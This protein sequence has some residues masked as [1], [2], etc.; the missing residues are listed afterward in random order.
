[1]PFHKWNQ[2]EASRITVADPNDFSFAVMGD[3]KGNHSVFEPLAQDIDHDKEIRFAIDCG[4]L[5]REGRVGL[6][7]RFL[8][9][10]QE[11]LAIPFLTAIGNHDLND[12]GSNKNYQEIFG[13]TY[14]SFQ[15]GQGYFI[16]LDAI[17]EA[18]FDKKER[19]WLENELQKSQASKACFVFMHVPV[20]DPRGGIFHKSLPDKDQQDLLDLFR[21]YKVTHLFASHLHGYFSGIWEGVP[22]TLTGGAGARLQGTDPEHFF[23][24]YVKVHVSQGKADI[25]VRR[26]DTANTVVFF[27]DLMEDYS[28]QWGLLTAAGLLPFALGLSI[29]KRRRSS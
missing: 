7:R 12:D 13:P 6:Y 8:Q 27:F 1:V 24:H 5:V 28:L 15:V 16:V 2:Q 18:D 19:Q 20:I 25:M 11:N 3:N 4:D 22:Y 14:Y 29:M 26:I 10:V 21:R 17:T 9:R 23:H